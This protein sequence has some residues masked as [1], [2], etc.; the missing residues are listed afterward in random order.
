MG[1]VQETLL[2]RE[3]LHLK[4]ASE[5]T[6]R[7]LG[8]DF[9]EPEGF[10]FLDAQIRKLATVKTDHDTTIHLAEIDALLSPDD[11]YA[12]LTAIKPHP[13]SQSRKG[14]V[15]DWRTPFFVENHAQLD[16]KKWDELNKHLPFLI[17]FVAG[18]QLG[19]NPWDLAA[20][21]ISSNASYLYLAGPDNP[22]NALFQSVRSTRTATNSFNFL[23]SY[24]GE[25]GFL[26]NFLEY[27]KKNGAAPLA[28]I[29]DQ[30]VETGVIRQ[31]PLIS[32][33]VDPLFELFTSDD[34]SVYTASRG[35]MKDIFMNVFGYFP[36]DNQLILSFLENHKQMTRNFILQLGADPADRAL[37]LMQQRK[38]ME[39]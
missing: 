34:G 38:P 37:R 8:R 4:G 23:T 21:F 14:A 16:P 20:D 25:G 18:P 31:K 9:P 22:D 27:Y 6:P 32:S 28:P 17:E 11:F 26:R 2:E 13:T 5:I 39:K 36:K 7:Q 33:E 24:T 12:L 30:L 29:I 10:A 3:G 19:L 35:Q 1:L 15:N